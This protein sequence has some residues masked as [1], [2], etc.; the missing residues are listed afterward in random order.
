MESGGKWRSVGEG[1][2][3]GG[4]LRDGEA[5]RGG[6]GGKREERDG[7]VWIGRGSVR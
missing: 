3:E 7:E 5:W 4:A 2:V 6:R 1:K